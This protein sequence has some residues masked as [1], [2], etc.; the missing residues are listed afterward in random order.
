MPLMVKVKCLIKTLD[1]NGG[2]G[3]FP[4]CTGYLNEEITLSSVPTRDSFS[5]LRWVD[6]Y[7]NSY[8]QGD[9]Y[10]FNG[11]NDTLTAKWGCTVT[12][13]LDGGE[14]DFPDISDEEL[15]FS[16]TPEAMPSKAG[17]YFSHWVSSRNGAEYQPGAT[18]VF[19]G[20]DT[21]T[22]VWEIAW[23]TLT[24]NLN[25]ADTPESIE[26][27]E[28]QATT[29]IILSSVIPVKEGFTF[30]RWENIDGDEFQPGDP[31]FFR[32][33]DDIL[34]AVWGY[35]VTLDPA[36]GVCEATTVVKP[37]GEA[38]DII[39]SK[40]GYTF[41]GW[42]RP[43]YILHTDYTFTYGNEH[44]TAVWGYTVSYAHTGNTVIEPQK[45]FLYTSATIHSGPSRI[46]YNFEGWFDEEGN[47]YAP[48]STHTFGSDITLTARWSCG[49]FFDANGGTCDCYLLTSP[50]GEYCDLP[51]A[52][53]EGYTFIKW[54]GTNGVEYNAD[55]MYYFI[56]GDDTLTAVWGYTV[57]LNAN[58][59]ECVSAVV[60]PVGEALDVIPVR[61]G[62]SF[63]KWVNSTG[64]EFDSSADYEFIYGNDTL[65]AVWECTLTYNLNGG[66][67][68]FSAVTM[69]ENESIVL[70]GKPTR[71][72][73][74]FIGWTD[75]SGNTY[76]TYD[77]YVFN[78]GN[79]TLT[80]SWR[81]K[82]Y[83]V[84]F[85]PQSTSNE[86]SFV[87]TKTYGSSL[88]LS[89]TTPTKDGCSFVNWKVSGK[90]KYYEAGDLYTANASLVLEPQWVAAGN[91]AVQ[92][93]TGDVIS[94]I[95]SQEVALGTEIAITSEIP[96][97]DG[98][99]FMGW[100]MESTTEAETYSLARTASTSN[101]SELLHDGDRITVTENK[102]C[103][104][105]FGNSFSIT[106]LD[107]NLDELCTQV[108]VCCSDVYVCSEIPE[109][110]G[111]EFVCWID[112]R[113][114]KTYMPGD[115]FTEHVD[116]TLV[117]K[118]STNTSELYDAEIMRIPNNNTV[119]LGTSHRLVAAV[120]P[121][122][123]TSINAWIS[124]DP[125]IA[126][127]DEKGIVSGVGLGSTVIRLQ[128]RESSE[129]NSTVFEDSFTVT[130]DIK[131]NHEFSYEGISFAKNESPTEADTLLTRERALC[132]MDEYYNLD[133][134]NIVANRANGDNTCIFAFEGLG[135]G[136]GGIS[137]NN[138]NTAPYCYHKL[139]YNF[140]NAMMVVTKGKKIKYVTRR[141]ST[142]PD[143]RPEPES[144]DR[145]TTL[146]DGIYE[147]KTGNHKSSYI[148]LCPVNIPWN[149]WYLSNDSADTSFNP[150]TA[151]GINLHAT[152]KTPLS[153][154]SG[155]HSQGCQTVY[156]ADYIEFGKQV[157]FLKDIS[158]KDKDFKSVSDYM[159][160]VIGKYYSKAELESNPNLSTNA[161]DLTVKYIVDRCFD[162]KNNNTDYPK[163]VFYP[164]S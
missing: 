71:T 8:Y 139:P 80:A 94:N 151:D 10:T 79:D 24:Y 62:Y 126:T 102:K 116:T 34:T 88:R 154:S 81:L 73:R 156:W 56:Y 1:L 159:P 122:Y 98:F 57:T 142:L 131:P 111:F 66:S 127:V 63:N 123:I 49:V 75:K 136:F 35:T 107:I 61:S 128:A 78:K 33:Y 52:T 25:D 58:G 28:G 92:Y 147:Y 36:G 101:T 133:E 59:G 117:S 32:H 119:Y 135:E 105:E 121:P 112:N 76:D 110:P 145:T 16:S 5:F 87:Q 85:D 51:I 130:V 46:G 26:A 143:W 132:K 104:A 109:A 68:S 100:R 70:D 69:L 20:N 38:L 150:G 134:I 155:A 153:P 149:S 84:Y 40:E 48:D 21:L 137:E 41:M 125:S 158:Y 89:S 146:I 141:A 118:W 44:L 148:A 43:N 17:Y 65:T 14:G 91:A 96:Y 124:D 83:T 129:V 50:E 106:Y 27:Q 114:G 64:L 2:S 30:V 115:T 97:K 15:V 74:N 7:G 12:Y 103:C 95:D 54:V 163:G 72:G 93:D 120:Y 53:R 162:Q 6:S 4:P 140:L 144:I 47:Y 45:H 138:Q 60:K 42:E 157:G 77:T 55:S 67:G 19:A 31:Y 18:Y 23:H 37:V 164:V 82:T 13:N 29:N 11:S 3:E 113:T 90:N 39:P 9:T 86:G 161:L 160:D 99:N 22:A 108:E 152:S